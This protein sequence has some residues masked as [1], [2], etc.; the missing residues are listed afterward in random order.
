MERLMERSQRERTERLRNE[1]IERV[2]TLVNILN[3]NKV[4][5][6]AATIVVLL[7]VTS[8]TY[9]LSRSIISDYQAQIVSMHESIMDLKSDYNQLTIKTDAERS[10]MSSQIQDLTSQLD[11]ANKLS[12]SLTTQVEDLDKQTK[13]LK[14]DNKELKAQIADREEILSKYS[15]ATTWGNHNTDLTYEQLKLGETLM[16]EKGYDPNLLFGIIMTES[17]GDANA[18]ST[19]STAT[20][21][22]QFLKGTG[23]FVYEDLLGHGKGTYNHSMA[24]NGTLNIQMMVAYLDYLIK[25]S[26]GSVTGAIKSYRGAGGS[27]L[28][29]Y[30]ASINS[31][32][33]GNGVSVYDM[34]Y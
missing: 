9:V 3:T 26:D 23:K 29:G 13:T 4:M 6:M 12:K 11:S 19:S 34:H 33:K 15:Y 25:N 18:K 30:I 14:A 22:G 32:I 21:Y 24:T 8:M 27:V 5:I 16:L 31:F 1:R 17:R 7:V 10:D 20:G 28:S 2:N